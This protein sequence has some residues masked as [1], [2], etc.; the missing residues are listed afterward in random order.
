[1]SVQIWQYWQTFVNYIFN[2]FLQVADLGGLN[3]AGKFIVMYWTEV[4]Y[5]GEKKEKA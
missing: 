5:T 2:G 3:H 4:E 1:M